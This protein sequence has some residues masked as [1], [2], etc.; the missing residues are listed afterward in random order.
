MTRKKAQA[1]GARRFQADMRRRKKEP[2]KQVSAS[3]PT[4]PAQGQAGDK[5]R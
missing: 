1:E 5:R 3:S 4:P 2:V